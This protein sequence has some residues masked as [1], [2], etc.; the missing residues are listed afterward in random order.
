[1]KNPHLVLI[2]AVF[3][4]AASIAPL[5]A[6]DFELPHY[7]FTMPALDSVPSESGGS[8][9]LTTYLPPP[10][11]KYAPTVE[12]AIR[13]HREDL[14]DYITG[15]KDHFNNRKW[16]ILEEKRNGGNE[17]IVE[18]SG[19]DQNRDLHFYSRALLS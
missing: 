1:M 6:A 16:A 19:P 17:W 12:V 15:L 10:D 8:S 11:G 2:A 5:T 14:G 4:C 13:P 9:P 7:G 3:G 18:Y